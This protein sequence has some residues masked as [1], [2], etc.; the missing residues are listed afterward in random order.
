MS[1]TAKVL[2]MAKR[3]KR[4]KGGYV[5]VSR[6]SVYFPTEGDPEGNV[7]VAQKFIEAEMGMRLLVVA[8][9]RSGVSIDLL[10]LPGTQAAMK[11]NAEQYSK[12]TGESVTYPGDTLIHQCVLAIRA[13]RDILDAQSEKEKAAPAEAGAQVHE[14]TAA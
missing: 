11:E 4:P 9:A 12:R 3:K 13:T 14:E 1:Q 6:Q 5:T 2:P 10:D 8:I 7:H